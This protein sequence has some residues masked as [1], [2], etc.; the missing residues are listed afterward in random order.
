MLKRPVFLQVRKL[1]V[2]EIAASRGD[3]SLFAQVF[4]HDVQCSDIGCRIVEAYGFGGADWLREKGY[5][6]IKTMHFKY[7]PGATAKLNLFDNSSDVISIN[8]S[9]AIYSHALYI[10][11]YTSRDV[12]DILLKQLEEFVFLLSVKSGIF[13]CK[14]IWRFTTFRTRKQENKKWSYLAKN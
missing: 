3:L 8:A 12:I 10:S 11:Q 7:S 4:G 9:G 13:Q 14:A 1:N 6:L 5:G 2:F